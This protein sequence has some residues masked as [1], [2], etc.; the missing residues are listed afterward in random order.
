MNKRDIKLEDTFKSLDTEEWL[1]IHYTRPFGLMMAKGFDRFDIHP[2]VVTILGI[3][4]GVAAGVCMF[5][6]TWTCTILGILLLNWA[7]FHDN[8]DGILARMTGKKTLWGR[9]LDGTASD[10]WFVTIYISISTRLMLYSGWGIW[11]WVMCTIAGLFCH[12]KQ[13]QLSDYYR[14]IHL[15]FL[16]G[17]AGSELDNKAQQFKLFK[18]TPWR[19]QIFWKLF[20]ISYVG[21]CG[22]QE[23]MTPHFQRFFKELR[24]RYG[25]NIP[26]SLREDFRQASLPMMK[27]TNILTHNTRAFVLFL[28]LIISQIL[29]PYEEG[30]PWKL[31]L[32]WLYPVFEMTVLTIIWWHMHRYHENMCK[33]M[34]RKLEQA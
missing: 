13:C 31:D 4:I 27:W 29:L 1:D 17:K 34:L 21:Y 22:A 8:A 28:S 30:T 32:I 14:N 23:R 7:N 16:K 20:L 11:S 12:S 19:G 15:F 18:D 33:E 24:Q 10:A 9:I 2:N 3:I 5:W 26:A 6:R 25:D